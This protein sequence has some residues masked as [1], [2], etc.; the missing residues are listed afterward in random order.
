VDVDLEAVR[1]LA[2]SHWEAPHWT[3]PDG[4]VTNW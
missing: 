1:Q 2:E 4:S 3:R